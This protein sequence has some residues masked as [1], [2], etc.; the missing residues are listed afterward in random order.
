VVTRNK[1]HATIKILARW[2]TSPDS[3]TV[4]AGEAGMGVYAFF[5]RDRKMDRHYAERGVRRRVTFTL[6]EDALVV[7][8][9]EKHH[10]RGIQ[11]CAHEIGSAMKVTLQNME[12]AYWSITTYV[13]RHFPDCVAYIVPHFTPSARSCQIVVRKPEQIIELEPR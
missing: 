10:L 6:P 3:L 12:R 9:R 11:Q 5:A 4:A 8:L 2:E 7:D 1:Q 13:E